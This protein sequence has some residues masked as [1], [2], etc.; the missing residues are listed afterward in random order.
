MLNSL[1]IENMAVIASLDVDLTQGLCAVTGET[2]SGKSV[3]IDCILFLLGGKPS[4]DLLRSGTE[5]GLVS[6]LF[7]DV[8]SECLAYL[9]EIGLDGEGEILLQRT[10]SADGKTQARFNGRVIPQAIL[11]EL[12]GYLVSVH[13]QND[14]QQLMQRGA[15]ERILDKA[16]ELSEL[17]ARYRARYSERS[18][19]LSALAELDRDGAE[20]ERQRDI[21]KFQIG[22]IDAAKL[23]T[24]EEEELLSKRE[25]LRYAEKI[26]TVSS[27]VYRALYGSE[28]GASSLLDRAASALSQI[29]SVVSDADHAARRLLEMR[30]ELED[31]AS[32]VEAFGEEIDGDPTKALDRVEGRL[33][34]ISSLCRKYGADI[35]EVLAFRENAAAKLHALDHG[36]EERERLL[37]VIAEHERELAVMADTLHERR[38]RAAA[39][40]GSAVREELAFLDMPA[41]R[42]EIAVKKGATLTPNGWDDISFCIA[43]NPG[44]PMLPLARI[45]SGGELARVT[46]A[47]K[48]VLNEMDGVGTAVFDEVDTGISGKT[49][50]KIGIKLSSIGKAT[51]VICVTHSAQIASLAHTHYRIAKHEEAGRAFATVTPLDLEGRVAEVAR[52]LGGLKLTAA[53]LTAARE[54][55][56]EGVAYR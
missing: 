20:K 11:R 36:E 49:S 19:A 27:F 26:T 2:G 42:F 34:L 21:L 37:S 56:E 54:M 7:T 55:I 38:E 39:A 31:I 18:A 51:Q 45:A 3:M 17:L 22:E 46:L 16:A 8:G 32:T 10:L 43:T 41:V 52:I 28:K 44:E 1:H 24:G 30:Y 15:Q 6:A 35:G 5:K 33:D 23:K 53:Q 25:R 9:E 4:R 29:A 48:S 47:I 50:R 13:G 12:S 40:L 14:H